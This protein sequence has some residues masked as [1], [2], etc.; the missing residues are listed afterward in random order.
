M[1]DSRIR[2][3]RSYHKRIAKKR[4]KRRQVL[5]GLVL[6]CAVLIFGITYLVLYRYVSQYPQDIICDN[7]YIGTTDVSSMTRDE[8]LQSMSAHL[9]EDQ[10]RTVTLQVGDQTAEATL[11][12]FGVYY[13][14]IEETVDEALAYGKKGSVFG[15]YRKLRKLKKENLVLDERMAVNQELAEAVLQERAVPIADH[16]KNASITRTSSGFSIQEE[17]EGTAVDLEQSIAALED[18]LNGGWDHG[19][20]ALELVLV[21]EEP[22]IKAADLESIQDE[23]GSFSTDAGGGQRW[24]NLETASG[25]LNGMILMPGDEVSVHDVTAPYDEEHGYVPA[26][27]YENG[28]VVDTYGGGICQVSTTLYNALL[29]AELEIVERYPHSMMVNY[30]DPSRDAAIAGDTKDLVFRNDQETPIYIEGGIDESNQLHFTIYGKETRDANRTVEYESET[31]AEEEYEVKYEEDPEAALGTVS[32]EGSPH[33]GR[34]AR[35]WKIVFVDG[36]E[37]EREVINESH[38]NKSDQ[39]I[40]IGTK[41]DNAEASAAVRSA[42]ATQDKSKIDAAVSQAGGE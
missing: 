7:I 23:L 26:G 28:Q 21:K 41:S 14:D 13:Q 12:E 22:Q 36:E 35:L 30:V 2:K 17:K 8:A 33:T 18:H 4:R 37:T 38:Y 1:T 40:K 9:T 5:F 19:D 10:A 42:I 11:E 24:Q 32:Y 31:V 29:Y 34:S 3:R 25:K 15:R 20:F 16:A 6:A 39:I 27:S